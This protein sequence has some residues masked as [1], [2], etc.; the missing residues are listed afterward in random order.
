MS[1]QN[2]RKDAAVDN[3]LDELRSKGSAAPSPGN[4]SID[5]IMQEL[6]KAPAPAKAPSPAKST[7]PATKPAAK[8]AKPATPATSS[9]AAKAGNA[10]PT[11]ENDL[12][13]ASAGK[14]KAKSDADNTITR[15]YKTTGSIAGQ[16]TI[17][18]I[19]YTH[20]TGVQRVGKAA[21]LDKVE[22]GK[23]EEEAE[24]LSWFSPN[25]GETGLSKRDK[26]RMEKERKKQEAADRRDAKREEK[27]RQKGEPEDATGTSPD[28]YQLADTLA[29]AVAEKKAGELT[30]EAAGQTGAA[31]K[32]P[33]QSTPLSRPAAQ[34]TAGQPA[35]Q[36][37]W[38]MVDESSSLAAN[39]VGTAPAKTASVTPVAKPEADYTASTRAPAPLATNNSKTTTGATNTK[40]VA[41]AQQNPPAAQDSAAPAQAPQFDIDSI[42]AIAEEELTQANGA[43]TTTSV[44]TTA[45]FA[46]SVVITE[47]ESAASSSK[48]NTTA[49]TSSKST[50][51]FTDTKAYEA[52]TEPEAGK[53]PTA[54]YT[55]EFET[56]AGKSA[57]QQLEEKEGRS[58]FLDDIVDDR[59]RAFF[60]ETVIDDKTAQTAAPN[61]KPKRRLRKT[62]TSLFTGEF[63]QLALDAQAQDEI[64]AAAGETANNLD[65][66][67]SPQD[68]DKIQQQL[69]DLRKAFGL[70]AIV[71][72]VLGVLLLWFTLSYAGVITMPFINITTQPISFAGVHLALLLAV[73][74]V[75]FKTMSAGL[76]GLFS[77][78]TVD[79]A[80]ALAAL[81]ALLQAVAV[82]VQVAG[83]SLPQVTLFG[84]IAAFILAAN[85]FGKFVRSRVILQNFQL[86]SGGFDHSAAYIVGSS[87][88]ELA[89][90]ITTGLE[91]KE[92]VL[93]VS[94]PTTFVKGFMKQSFSLRKSDYTGRILGWVLGGAALLVAGITLLRGG[95]LAVALSAATGVLC[96][97]A[98]LSSTLLSAI[99][100]AI[101]QQNNA[102]VGAVVPGWS[103]IDD[104]SQVNCVMAG[105]R[106]IF[107]PANVQITGIKTYEKERID[108]AILYAA[109]VLIE[110]C[111]TL[112]DIFNGVIQGKKDM[113]YK[114][115]SL[116]KEPGRGFTA[117]VENQRIVVGTREMLRR[118]AIEPPD[119]ET[120]LQCTK[121][122]NQPVYL[123][124]SGKL[125]ARFIIGYS[126]DPEVAQTLQSL[127]TS[128]VSLLVTSDDMNI[129][130]DFI[131][132][133]YALP[134]GMVKVLGKKELDI[135]EPMTSYQPE[136]AGVMTHIGTFISF[137]GGMR[138]AAACALSEK[139]S[140]FVQ[141][142]SVIFAVLIGLLLAVSGGLSGLSIGVVLLYQLGWTL[143]VCATPLLNRF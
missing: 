41:Q 2:K 46:K 93:L 30:G 57:T 3:I 5:S 50:S 99:P 56:E 12:F 54:A 23:Y 94:R 142:A 64:A 59:F 82:L 115:E 123:A 138:A 34:H 6:G 68:A 74:G 16:T 37:S 97:G 141:I 136:S 118:H 9:T 111:D 32:Q 88:Y 98:P 25:E 90:S 109:S 143:F 38:L 35:T 70:R 124:V 65:E 137:I 26:R 58:L 47:Q 122:G 29:A 86:T 24:L 119:I 28:I 63:A 78:P 139:W 1:N 92:P 60:G 101:M 110:G 108:L 128:G 51:S 49:P 85:M 22:T 36:S 130:S 107:P 132:K 100:S 113:L 67:D 129:T 121:G 31:P 114:V 135:L 120:E 127:V 96:I 126:A 11:P 125:Y 45:V 72:A 76:A 95:N 42:V 4:A 81:F 7:A 134:Q 75:N 17:L 106:D 14:K 83:G 140:G 15:G 89:H 8:P 116:T 18:D 117:W 33:A 66:L 39:S 80:P 55:Q 103:A 48:P 20:T 73:V 19:Q 53:T 21:A 13:A 77:Q 91:E 40:P 87:Q 27:R 44:E 71:S 52:P 69:S 43:T 133:L 10:S 131:E 79:T 112:R 61:G 104:L 62:R 84:C 105:A 102:K